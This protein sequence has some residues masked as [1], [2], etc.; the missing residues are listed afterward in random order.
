MEDDNLNML[1]D[2]G[3]PD[4]LEIRRALRLAK[5]D[6]GE[7][8]GIL[9]HE[10]P[11]PSYD[12]L[13]DIDMKDVGTK[14]YG[15]SLPPA[16]EV[17]VGQTANTD[18]DQDDS[19]AS[20]EFPATNLYELEGR[21]FTDNWSIPYKKD[22]SLGKCLIAA[23]RRANEGLLEADENC[24]RFVERCMP[25]AFKKLVK[26]GAVH[27]WGPEIQEGIYNMLTLFTDLAAARLKHLP[28]PVRLLE[29]LAVAFDHESEWHYKNKSRRWDKK[30]HWEDRLGADNLFAVSPPANSYKEPH[31][32]LVNLINKFGEQGGIDMI[33]R[34]LE[35]EEPDSC[36]MA[37]LLE[38]LGLC[39]EYLNQKK[40][41]TLLAPGL[42][43][44]VQYIQR[45]QEQDLK[46]K[47]VAS[48]AHL[49][50][51]IKLLSLQLWPEKV[52]SID[53]LRL[54]VA[55][56]ML[57]SP[58][59]NARMNSLKEVTKLIDDSTSTKPVK[60]AIDSEKILD[61][62]VNNK[63]LSIALEGNIDQA[64]YCD[65]IKG[66]VEFLGT[67][68]TLEE[69]SKI[70]QLQTG[71]HSTVIENIHSLMASASVKF[72]PQQQEHLFVLIQKSWE[73]E[74]DRIREKLL[75]LIGR[76]GKEARV[77]RTTVKVLD[78]LWELAHLPTLPM[79]L[80]ESALDAHFSILS[81]SF[82]VKEQLKKNYIMKCIDDIKK[83]VWVL[84]ALRQLNSI[85]RSIAK[86]TYNKQEKSMISDLNKSHE[87][88]KMVISSL[89]RFHKMA[90]QVPGEC[91]SPEKMVDGRYMHKQYVAG[92]LQFLHFVLREGGLYLSWSRVKELW[93]TLINNPQACDFD[94]ETCYEW[95]AESLCDLESET[96]TQLFHQR[97][98]KMDSTRLSAT[99]FDCFK[100]V[101]ESI[102]IFEHRLKR[103][104]NT[105]V[106]DKVE[107]TGMDYLWSV[108]LESS[109]EPLADAAVS[110]LIELLYLNLAPRLKKDAQALHRRFIND[111]YK[112]LEACIITLGNSALADAISQATKVLTA[113]TV[114]EV[115][116]V[117]T[118]SRVGRLQN[119]ERLLL[120]AER[121]V[122][123]VEDH[124]VPRTILP[125]ALSF[126]GHPVALHV[127]C[128]AP[129]HEF[130]INAHSNETLASVKERVAQYLK[131][132]PEQ[133]QLA[134]G[135]SILLSSQDQ[136][137]L[138]QLEFQD[139]QPLQCKM[140]IATVGPVVPYTGTYHQPV[141]PEESTKMEVEVSSASA[142]AS[143]PNTY[144]LDHERQW[145]GVIMAAG[146]HVFEMFYQL[147]ELDDPRIRA[148][149][150]SLLMLIPTDSSVLDALDSIGAKDGRP[151]PP[152]MS[153]VEEAVRSP[154]VSPRLSPRKRQEAST[155]VKEGFSSK[156][157]LQRLF[158]A[159]APSMSTFRVVYNLQVL[160][161]KLMPTTGDPATLKSAQQF[162]E[163]FLNAGGL[164]L[165]VNVLQR[166]A[167][168]SDVDYETRQECCSIALQLASNGDHDDE[169]N[170]NNNGDG[171]NNDENDGRDRG[172]FYSMA[173]VGDFIVDLLLGCPNDDVRDQARK[174]FLQLSRTV[175]PPL[176]GAAGQTSPHHFI[177]HVL[178]KAHLPLWV[179]S[180]TTR[181]S[182]QRLLAQC[183]Q[184]FELRAKL[185]ENL[186]LSE[187]Q[188][189]QVT[190]SAMLT[191]ELEWLNN[192]S[193]S[194]KP[195][196]VAGD[197]ALLAGH[198]R[199]IRSLLMCEGI[200]K[201]HV[202]KNLLEDLLSEFLFPASKYIENS[203]SPTNQSLYI[204]PK[205]SGLES[206]VAA[207]QVLVELCTGCLQNQQLVSGHLINMHHKLATDIG[208]E[209][210]YLPPVDGR[211]PC[212]FV[213]LKNGGA[214][215]YMNSVIQQLYM[216]PDICQALLAVEGEENE[217]SVF[218]Q[219]QVVFGNLLESKLQYYSPTKF[220][221]TFKL[222][223]RPVNVRE[224]QD[225]FEFY[226]DLLNQLDEHLIKL[227]KTPIFKKKFQGVFSDQKICKDCPHRYEREETFAALNLTV[228]TGCLQDSLAQYVKGE[229]LEGDNAYY[230]E[231]CGT[232]RTAVKRTC[233]KT[234]PPELC[235]QLKRFD[236]DWEANRALK[237]DD[238][239]RFPWV[240]D[241]EPYTSEG[242]A[243]RESGDNKQE[244]NMM[245]TNQ[246][247]AVA[248][249]TTYELVG[250]AV[251]SGQA[252]AG[253]YYS[254]IKDRSGN[255]LTNANRGKWFKYNDTT[256]EE[257]LMNNDSLEAECFGGTYKAKVYDQS[258]S[259][260]ETRQRYWNGYMLFYEKLE[261]LR[262]P[263]M[264]RKSRA[265]QKQQQLS[266]GPSPCKDTDRK[267]SD[268]L[269]ELS[270]LVSAG[271]R[272][273]IFTEQMPARI[274]QV[275]REENLRFMQN[276]DVFN[277]EYFHL[278]YQLTRCNTT[279]EALQNHQ[280]A[281]QSVQLAIQ[282]L[283]T[284]YFRTKR[285]LRADTCEWLELLERILQNSKEACNWL[286]DFLGSTKGQSFIGPLL[287]NC[288]VQDVRV[289]FASILQKTFTYF[290]FHG[291]TTSSKMFNEVIE[292][293]LE[294]LNKEVQD[295][296]KQCMQYFW[297]LCSYA[298]MGT[299]ACAHLFG[300]SGFQRLVGF[301]IGRSPPTTPTTEELQPRRWSSLQA[302]EFG[303]LHVAL[304]TLVLHCDVTPYRTVAT[305]THKLPRLHTHVS[306]SHLK[307]PDDV[308]S[309]LYGPES[310][311]YVREV[312]LSCREI[313]SGDAQANVDMVVYCS[314][315]NEL[316][317]V[318]I[319][320][321]IMNL[322]ASIASNELKPIFELLMRV[323]LLEDPLQ[324]YRLQCIIDG[325]TDKEKDMQY[326]G[327][328]TVIKMNHVSDSRRSYQ[329][330]KFLVNLASKCQVAKDYLMQTPSKWQWA[331]N[332]LKKK[333]T[334]HCWPPASV[335]PASN[336]DSNSKSFQRTIS[337]QDTLA[338]A[339]AL[340]TEIESSDQM[341]DMETGE[342]ELSSTATATTNDPPVK[343]DAGDEQTTA[344]A[345]ASAIS[346]VEV[347]HASAGVVA[348]ATKT[349]TVSPTLD[350]MD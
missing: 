261:D 311:R 318:S 240:L 274:Q 27:R 40:F 61:W 201:Q 109:D 228:K 64:Q 110:Y 182:S 69:L 169:D 117:P 107:L 303:Q 21:V 215:C 143:A 289:D 78:L 233:I 203:S 34:R 157:T 99:G 234:L 299:K 222:W 252:N 168:S 9:T 65:K 22:E 223:G 347:T 94:R 31:G 67:R 159:C 163:D 308:H 210:E 196:L 104:S 95:F 5:N 90:V 287:L 97:I 30:D 14:T 286:V 270:E 55:L 41:Q 63:V 62:L 258:S 129:K 309:M 342:S 2:M 276:R 260:P 232:K 13:D 93:D 15:P 139:V 71:Q 89:S 242:L 142:S 7:A 229:L 185:L 285:S 162:C 72:S 84:P 317:S 113:S 278:L 319:L 29:T 134:A 45:L 153:G 218:Y 345:A 18:Q 187:Q 16:Y 118:P 301:L 128:D 125:H 172:T 100:A 243:R 17:V 155:S 47:R 170:N 302:R 296:C 121:Y 337:A 279:K 330:I 310:L 138:Y 85:A 267:E 238:H 300:K 151:P 88:I 331:V 184:Y 26:S 154:R 8:V 320:R 235:M 281:L 306:E 161:A 307:M 180:G 59:F 213:G 42:D 275:V 293:L 212:G 268:S 52:E 108:A 181:G 166:D 199:L 231:K 217:D 321:Q 266:P 334:D 147:A 284:V 122:T 37:A 103:F 126:H 82:A 248:V 102:N 269:S 119:I 177:L 141:Q 158:D 325:Y 350:S 112:R 98:L 173:C 297:L 323:L 144:D 262:A 149:V 226:T 49:L 145:P 58:H 106:V 23:T 211:A 150:R 221:D 183:T 136:K 322:Y 245:E 326:D 4:P 20:F 80:V 91:L 127:A 207:Y 239:F 264:R 130:S 272:R 46:H 332:W 135:D 191:D 96:Q 19:N 225:A 174:Q 133:I 237:F 259:Y 12:V 101:F 265:K 338:E 283:F 176:E 60:H 230:C 328:L 140:G 208:N 132:N 333:M 316:F 202:G 346:P 75:N 124:H 43:K 74:T 214:T 39:A 48:V 250:V 186:T 92:H 164:G 197:N 54:E 195:S 57:K 50:G 336:E 56:R 87:I 253:H 189:L 335:L 83:G 86:Q 200:H 79:R 73:V 25:E 254:F 120:I 246:L 190:V 194:E 298:Q 167:M 178:L 51:A 280:V 188:D 105:M 290:F 292:L 314:F 171:D 288:P 146:G 312:A 156:L 6:V 28:V 165:V 10:N 3:F 33:K 295:N 339:T 137:L 115:A 340:L 241:M 193:T 24:R 227:N 304:A 66:I 244:D 175:C 349:E 70:W 315:C 1:L 198:F 179:S 236:Y 273:G 36:V 249:A 81:D 291:G 192:F 343:M 219:M 220:W 206:R 341:S 216:Q 263:R 204:N 148:R 38:P 76:I 313:E 68:L 247:D 329:C 32:L 35:E 255:A 294:M 282:F 77:T 348:A 205:C 344:R 160:S 131:H 257:F 152:A 111:C 324:L 209:W 256:V 114:A 251:H 11:S 305:G 271:E 224:Q 327:M 123:T 44:C 53:N 277:A 116:S